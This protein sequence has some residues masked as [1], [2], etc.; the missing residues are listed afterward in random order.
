MARMITLLALFVLGFVATGCRGGESAPQAEPVQSAPQA[1]PVENAPQAE[2]VQSAPQAEPVENAPQAGPVQS[3]PHA[4][5]LT[6]LDMEPV[7]SS[8]VLGQGTL[9]VT[10]ETGEIQQI[11]VVLQ[12]G[13]YRCTAEFTQDGKTEQRQWELSL[14]ELA[15]GQNGA[16]YSWALWTSP[17]PFGIRLFTPGPGNNFLAWVDV[18]DVN[19][20]DVSRPLDREAAFRQQ[21]LSSEPDPQVTRVFVKDLLPEVE[22]WGVYDSGSDIRIVSVTRD[23]AGNWTIVIASPEGKQF[24]IVG[25]GQNWHLA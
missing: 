17:S 10:Q 5:V 3:A 6:R 12:Q 24:T 14:S 18:S 11:P 22:K 23:E 25:D 16:D 19:I 15:A 2:P 1:E 7:G 8:R 4:R 9:S 13:R 20:A 21:W